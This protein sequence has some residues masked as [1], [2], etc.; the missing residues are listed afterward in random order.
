MYGYATIVLSFLIWLDSIQ[1]SIWWKNYLHR[2]KSD[3]L[4]PNLM[5][6]FIQASDGPDLRKSAI[7]FPSCKLKSTNIVYSA[8]LILNDWQYYPKQF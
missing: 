1:I 7:F 2:K 8:Y 5:M 3:L 4:S 6:Q